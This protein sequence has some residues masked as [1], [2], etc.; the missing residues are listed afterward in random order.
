MGK[1]KLKSLVDKFFEER[2]IIK[3]SVLGIGRIIRYMKDR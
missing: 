1:E 2:G 3:V